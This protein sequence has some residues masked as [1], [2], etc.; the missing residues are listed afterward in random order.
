MGYQRRSEEM[1]NQKIRVEKEDE[2]RRNWGSGMRQTVRRIQEK[3]NDYLRG[4]RKMKKGGRWK[5][6]GEKVDDRE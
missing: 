6:V 2:Y 1:R 5:V 3:V 4:N